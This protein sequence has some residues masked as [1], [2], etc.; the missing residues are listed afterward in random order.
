MPANQYIVDKWTPV[1]LVAGFVAARVGCSLAVT[2]IAGA[3]Y[4]LV[5]PTFDCQVFGGDYTP[6][7]YVPESNRNKAADLAALAGGWAIGDM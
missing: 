3:I 6:E 7:T 4:E 2:M 1:H 5:E